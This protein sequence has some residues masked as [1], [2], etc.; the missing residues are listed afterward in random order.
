VFKVELT[1]DWTKFR[2]LLKNYD[3]R[4]AHALRLFT[5]DVAEFFMEEVRK[6]IPAGSDFDMYRESL[7]VVRVG[8]EG[9]AYAVVSMR[10]RE[11]LGGIK[12]DDP[13][14]GIVVSMYPTGDGPPKQVELAKALS[15]N[16][17]W[18]ISQVPNGI[19]KTAV[20]LV[21][22][23]VLKQEEEHARNETTVFLGENR[24]YLQSLGARF[25]KAENG[26]TDALSMLS[27][28]DF[29][30]L[31]LRTEFGINAPSQAHWRP[32]LS[33][34]RRSLQAIIDDNDEL[35]QTLGDPNYNGHMKA[36][37]SDSEFWATQRYQKEAREFE[38]ALG[39]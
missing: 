33:T 25:G 18:T 35:Q 19:S 39:G 8:K 31:A 23:R 36:I 3:L 32:A 9:T 2:R 22:R 4:I 14:F 17:F 20:R 10:S 38:K 30:T 13:R 15:D 28:P 11:K 7:S 6:G 26:I 1:G 12:E 37:P 21:H 29:M 5:K 34:L 24:T 27:L 16:P